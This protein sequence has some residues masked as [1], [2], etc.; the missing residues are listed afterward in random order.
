[1]GDKPVV[2]DDI[3]GACLLTLLDCR[4]GFIYA[5]GS[6]W[7]SSVRVSLGYQNAPMFYECGE[8]NLANDVWLESIYETGKVEQDWE[9]LSL[10]IQTQQHIRDEMSRSDKYK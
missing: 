5:N 2:I 3:H 8:R 4:I 1:M 10:E 7:L 9:E 6:C